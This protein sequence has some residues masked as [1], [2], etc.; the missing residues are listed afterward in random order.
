LTI[1]RT[2]LREQVKDFLLE[3]ILNGHYPPGARLVEIQIAQELGTSQAPVREALRDLESL[4]FVESLPFRGCRVR[5]ITEEELV[6]IYPVRAA[7][8]EVAA[9][10]ATIRLDGDVRAL[11]AEL[12][13][14]LRAAAAGDRHDHVHHDAEFHRIIVQASGNQTLYGVWRSLRIEARTLITALKADV[15][16]H[17]IAEMHR[18]VMQAIAARDPLAAGS[19]L[20]QH[21]EYFG[22]MLRTSLAAGHE[23]SASG[24]EDQPADVQPS[25]N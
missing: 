5:Q 19:I 20:R 18:P 16:L 15:D 11:R 13:A 4:R 9:R 7:L 12:D 21:L 6:E 14:M 17:E 25:S 10:D 23:P 8:E 24:R 22:D 3:R 1:S 2:V